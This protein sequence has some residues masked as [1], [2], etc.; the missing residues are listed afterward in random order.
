MRTSRTHPLQI[1][2]VQ[3]APGMGFVGLTL[4]PGKKQIGALTGSWDRDLDLDLDALKMWNAAVVVS[5]VEAHE[6]DRLQ[7]PH[8]GEEI[9]KKHIDWYHLP[10]PDRGVP[11]Q[12][13]EAAW[14]KVGESLR[15]RLRGG[16]NV[17]VH[18]MG[19][20]GRAGTISSRLLAE[21]GWSASDAINEV[22]RVRPGAIETAGQLDFVHGCVPVPERQPDQD[23]EAVRDRAIG[24]LIGLAVGDALGTTLEFS[25]RDSRARLSD[26]EGGGPFRLKPGQWTDDTSM[27]LALADSLIAC[28]GL[29]EHDL[30]NSLCPLARGGSLFFHGNLFRHRHDRQRRLGTLPGKRK[31]DRWI[32]RSHECGQWKLD[33]ALARGNPLLGQARVAARCSGTTKPD[34]PWCCRG[35]GC[36]C[37]LRRDACRCDRGK[38]QDGSSGRAFG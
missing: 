20:L 14:A 10:I 34:N 31:S 25:S 2:Q 32:N 16:F 8:L 33:A 24:A 6:L 12:E 27:A 17:L 38:A 36:L 21:L 4:C 11:G 29:D 1:A 15:A 30:M 22:R 23:L 3:P 13:F 19:G 37:R 7:V 9:R 18:C 28:E 5:L 26:M 35:G